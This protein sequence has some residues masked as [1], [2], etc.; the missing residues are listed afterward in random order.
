MKR[1][2]ALLVI[3]FVALVAVLS[4][5][6]PTTAHAD[7]GPKPSINITLKNLDAV[8]YGTLLSQHKSTGPY[9]A[10]DPEEGFDYKDFGAVDSNYYFDENYHN[11]EVERIWQIFA[12]YNDSDE[13]FFLQRW[14]KLGGESNQLV[15]SYYPPYSFKL[16][17]YYP[18]SNTFVISKIYER[19]AF[20]SYYTVDMSNINDI[21]LNPDLSN[22]EQLELKQ[23]YNYT[24]E[25]ISLLC[26]II[27]TI[28]IEMAVAFLFRIKGRKALT[29][30]LVTNAVTQIALNVAL[31]L[32]CYFDGWMMMIFLYLPLELGVLFVE[33]VTYSIVLRKQGVP[34][35]KALLYALVANVV[36]GGLGFV[37]AM[38]IPGL[39]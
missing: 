31:N 18:D 14:W 7:M 15:W 25:I 17:L 30:I 19:Y 33:A 26:R 38:Y 9:S 34:I 11:E 32:L 5:V 13:Y 3:C 16:L 20:D 35:W 37:L 23:S 27:L 28:A 1:N 2:S 29:T 6:Q 22:G 21:L 39:F 4:F 36:S 24:W 12:D 10:Y 8:C